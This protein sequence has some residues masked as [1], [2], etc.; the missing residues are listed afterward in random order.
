MAVLHLVTPAFLVG[1]HI[2]DEQQ[3]KKQERA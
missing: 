3:D 2:S 1:N